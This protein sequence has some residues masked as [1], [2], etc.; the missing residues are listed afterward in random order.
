MKFLTIFANIIRAVFLI[1]TVY[2]IYRHDFKKLRSTI[3][4]F[5]LTF[6]PVFLDR[7]FMLRADL[8]GN[9]L[10]FII[11]V[12]SLYLGSELK[13]YDKFSWWDRVLH[14]L[15]GI[16]F[17]SFGIPLAVKMNI[18]ARI[19]VLFFCFTLSSTLHILW[20][21]AEYIVDMIA[22]TDHQRWQKHSPANNHLSPKAVQPA[23]LVDTMNDIIICML[24]T[25]AACVV[26]WF[27]L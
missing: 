16:M 26:W 27:I 3:I 20:E 19:G 18:S 15:C 11:I 5:V 4:V 17:V 22:H 1:L 13:F 12:M 24:S 21:V 6:V 10:Y 9:V 14:F 23:G 7:V 25:V 8:L 2:Y